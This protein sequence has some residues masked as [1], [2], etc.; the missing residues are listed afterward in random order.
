MELPARLVGTRPSVVERVQEHCSRYNVSPPPD[1]WPQVEDILD[2]YRDE[3]ILRP[4]RE[5]LSVPRARPGGRSL[6]SVCNCDEREW[7]A[8]NRSG[9]AP[10]FDATVFSC[11][12][13]IA[14]PE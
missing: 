3:A 5:I 13:G 14:K 8:R 12:L 2:R 4:H 6:G 9:P 7:R 1:L 10:L 11:E